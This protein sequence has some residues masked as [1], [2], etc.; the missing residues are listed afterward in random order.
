[1]TPRAATSHPHHRRPAHL[2]RMAP[3][4]LRDRQQTIS[5]RT[6][7][8][9]SGAPWPVRGTSFGRDVPYSS[10]ERGSPIVRGSETTGEECSV[11]GRGQ[12]GTRVQGKS[13][14]RLTGTRQ[15]SSPRRRPECCRGAFRPRR[16]R[17][18]R[19]WVQSRASSG[20]ST[21]DPAGQSHSSDP[22]PSHSQHPAG[23][24]RQRPIAHSGALTLGGPPSTVNGA[25]PRPEKPPLAD[26]SVLVAADP[27][28]ARRHGHRARTVMRWRAVTRS[29]PRTFLVV[30]MSR[31]ISADFSF[32]RPC[33]RFGAA[34]WS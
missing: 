17:P 20:L 25:T 32:G 3:T 29:S 9:R 4:G 1:M 28:R 24:R 10:R 16:H 11:P 33:R 12:A 6:Q 22:R 13:A 18:C 2:Y 8:R 5:P 26:V 7:T 23:R 21:D 15:W 19:Q 34:A 27:Q 14:W 30:G 31:G